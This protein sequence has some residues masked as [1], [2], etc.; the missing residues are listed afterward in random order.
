M[1]WV[2]PRHARLLALSCAIHWH[3]LSG[4]SSLAFAV[5]LSFLRRSVHQFP[6]LARRLSAWRSTLRLDLCC[7][8]GLC[9]ARMRCLREFPG[10]LKVRP[11]GD[12]GHSRRVGRRPELQSCAMDCTFVSRVRVPRT[13]LKRCKRLFR[14]LFLGSGGWPRRRLWYCSWYLWR[15]FRVCAFAMFLAIFWGI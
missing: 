10:M 1:C 9:L 8:P 6:D 4:G 3:G 15:Y 2:V 7:A 11:H 13:L 14:F 12:A 5:A